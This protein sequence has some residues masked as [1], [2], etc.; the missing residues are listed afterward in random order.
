MANKKCS[1]LT[2][3]DF[4]LPGYKAGGPIR[5]LAN[6][7]DQLGD[8]FEFK[9]ITAD[10]DFDD[11]STYKAITVGCWNKVSKADVFYLS[12]HMRSIKEFRKVI[13]STEYDVIYLNSFF[14]PRFTIQILLLRRLR[15]IPDKPLILAPRGEFSLGALALKRLKKRVYLLL[16]KVFG[17]CGSIIWQASSKHEEA[18]IRLWFVDKASV[19]IAPDIPPAV[20]AADVSLL[21][22]KKTKGSLKI[23]FLSRL[24]R[25]K[26]LDT[27]LK[28]LV[29][30]KGKIHFDIYGP[31]EDKGYWGECEKIIGNLPENINIQY[32]GTVTH[33]RVSMVMSEHDLFFLP[34]LG[35]NFGH[36]I[37]E[38]LVAGSP[39]LLSD[40]T[41]WRDLQE[42]G[43]GWDLSLAKPDMFQDV[44]QNCVDMDD[45]EYV[46]WS[47][48]A[49]MYGLAVSKDSEVVEQNRNLFNHAVGLLV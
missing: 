22:E 21:K 10:R 40:Q 48:R 39:V 24:S 19:A 33:E 36:V 11:N 27:A 5:T 35:E 37:L 30:L 31:I 17:L 41:P 42:K 12:P 14:S 23:I 47:E 28:M 26:N 6:M 34:T 16:A 13:C 2:F 38:A 43:V 25:K 20:H 29:G 15:L 8:E 3:T 18:D 9:I 7:V 44:L 1:I 32:C 4:Y 46:K 45:V 49:R